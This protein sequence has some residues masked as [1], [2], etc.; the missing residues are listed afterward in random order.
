ME[1]MTGTIKK[2]TLPYTI[3]NMNCYVGSVNNAIIL[4]AFSSQGITVFPSDAAGVAELCSPMAS[5]DAE[6]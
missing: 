6:T 5:A 1:W 4:S 3:N 2:I